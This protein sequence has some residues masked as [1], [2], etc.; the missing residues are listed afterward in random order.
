VINDQFKA[1]FLPKFA[2]ILELLTIAP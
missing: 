1:K 2:K